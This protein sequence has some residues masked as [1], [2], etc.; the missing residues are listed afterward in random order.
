LRVHLVHV[1]W[2]FIQVDPAG[3]C[4]CSGGSSSDT[5]CYPSAYAPRRALG[6]DI[7]PLAETIAVLFK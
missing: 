1:Q 5:H 4:H 6:G 7:V 2:G 3:D